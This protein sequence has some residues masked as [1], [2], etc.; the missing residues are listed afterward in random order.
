MIRIE[1]MVTM[2]PEVVRMR[3]SSTVLVKASMRVKRDLADMAWLCVYNVGPRRYGGGNCEE[4]V[5]K[6]CAA[7]QAIAGPARLR[8][9]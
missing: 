3:A 1:E 9:I 4:G 2:P 7:M 8:E 5:W 6:E